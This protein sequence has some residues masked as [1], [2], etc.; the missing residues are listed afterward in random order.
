MPNNKRAR[1]MNDMNFETYVDDSDLWSQCFASSG[2]T[3]GKPALFL[4]RDGAI[5]EEINY[6]QRPEDL[7]LIPGA[8]E[9]I[10]R[11]NERGVTTVL[12][13][14]QAG[15]GRGYFG[16]HQFAEVQE[17]LVTELS[18]ANAHLD[19]VFACPHHSDGKPPHQHP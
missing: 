11:A 19:A 18:A 17:K 12:I 14:N 3:A 2:K 6:L 7:A 8:T 5:V 1:A 16:W 9:T 4:D 13:T 15:I 10:A